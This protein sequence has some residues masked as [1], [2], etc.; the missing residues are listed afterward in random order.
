MD[1]AHWPPN[2]ISGNGEGGGGDGGERACVTEAVVVAAGRHR[3]PLHRRS[4]QLS[5]RKVPRSGDQ[6]GSIAA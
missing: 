3:C 6:P 5:R 2:V 1:E 4:Y